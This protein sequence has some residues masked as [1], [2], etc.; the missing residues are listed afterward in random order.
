MLLMKK[1]KLHFI[2]NTIFIDFDKMITDKL[3]LF[4]I[5]KYVLDEKDIQFDYFSSVYDEVSITSK[6]L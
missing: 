3:Y 2:I 6:P 1:R 5:L 4:N